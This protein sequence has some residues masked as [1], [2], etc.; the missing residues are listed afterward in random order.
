MAAADGVVWMAGLEV[1][2]QRGREF[3]SLDQ[4]TLSIGK[5]DEADLTIPDDAVSRV[6][7]VLER[8]GPAWCVR[9]LGSRNGTLLNGERL[10]GERA[11]HDGDELAIGRTRIVYR[12]QLHAKEP[13]TGALEPPPPL[14]PRESDVLIELCRP[15]LS[16]NAFTQPASVHDIAETLVVT[17]AAVKQHLSRLYD[18]FDIAP[19]PT[20]TRRVQLANEAI[21]RGAVRI[22]DLTRRAREE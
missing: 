10:F 14:T 15:L 11:I 21:Q 12:D 18:K 4:G 7:L 9:D 6:H 1:V 8:F 19:D 2:G 16:G 13:T 20:G 22:S 17:Q 5:S 3:I